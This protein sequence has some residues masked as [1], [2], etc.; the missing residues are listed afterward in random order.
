MKCASKKL[1]ERK[2]GLSRNIVTGVCLAFISNSANA[3]LVWLLD[4]RVTLGQGYEDNFFLSSNSSNEDEVLTT[5]LTGELAL[6]GKSERADVETLFRLDKVKYNKDADRLNDRDN[7]FFGVSSSYKASERNTLS[8]NGTLTR[9]T[10]VR[11]VEIITEPEVIEGEDQVGVEGN[12]DFDINLVEQNVRST[13]TSIGPSWSFAFSEHTYGYMS[14]TYA[15]RSYSNDSG[16]GL[17]E[18]DTQSVGIGFSHKLSE[19]S[20]ITGSSSASYFRPDNDRDVDTI[21]A[22]LG[23]THKF[24]ETFQMDFS[25]GGRDS[26]FDNASRSSDSGFV[27]NIGA[28]K[29]AGVTT[30]RINI[31]RNVNPSGS[32]DQVETDKFTMQVNHRLSPTLN[33]FLNG[34]YFDTEVTGGGTSNSDREF[35]TIRPGLSW[36]ILPSWN[37]SVSYRYRERDPEIGDSGESQGAFVSFSYS[38]PRQF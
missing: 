28:T 9:D 25:F 1:W 20:R 29:F 11:T 27:A 16:T 35:F 21:A 18:H 15:D 2:S 10:I 14:Y 33:F 19:R 4:P 31:D 5:T 36:Q 37:A 22:K 6:R 30:Y 17:V 3:D 24:S 34:R 8:L 26:E 32:G 38:P 23:L 12:E 7:Q 13:R